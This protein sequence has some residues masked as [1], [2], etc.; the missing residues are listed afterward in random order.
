MPTKIPNEMDA[1]SLRKPQ[2]IFIHPRLPPLL[3][4]GRWNL[5]TFSSKRIKSVI[6]SSGGGVGTAPQTLRGHGNSLVH[7]RFSGWMDDFRLANDH[8]RGVAKGANHLPGDSRIFLSFRQS[9]SLGNC[10]GRFQSKRPAHE[11]D[12]RS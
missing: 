5:M 10:D 8:A 2:A 9:S 11:I 6:L 12:Y 4:K 3:E 1:S 7:D